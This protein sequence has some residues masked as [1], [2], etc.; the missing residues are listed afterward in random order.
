MVIAFAICS[1]SA[2]AIALATRGWHWPGAAARD[3]TSAMPRAFARPPCAD[4]RN[5]V[6]S[7]PSPG[8]RQHPVKST[9][10]GR[11]NPLSCF[12]L[13]ALRRASGC[14]PRP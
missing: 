3:R 1:S 10:R 11:F 6:A 7:L 5:E 14:V 4:Q 2:P 9:E 12:G 13:L 8:H